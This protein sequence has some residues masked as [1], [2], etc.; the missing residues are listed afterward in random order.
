MNW[1]HEETG[2][3]TVTVVGDDGAVRVYDGD[4]GEQISGPPETGQAA[5]ESAP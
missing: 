3:G 1:E 5:T 2:T 4:T